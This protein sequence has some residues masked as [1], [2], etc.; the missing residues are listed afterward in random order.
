MKFKVRIPLQYVKPVCIAAVLV[1]IFA[2]AAGS[3]I[4]G[5]CLLLGAYLLPPLRQKA[6]YEVPAVQGQLLPG[7]QG[8]AA[9]GSRKKRREIIGL[10]SARRLRYNKA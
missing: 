5:L 6:G 3:W 4:T 8:R 10:F 2:V 7:L 1:G 9:P